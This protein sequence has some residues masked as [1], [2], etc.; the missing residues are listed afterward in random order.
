MLPQPGEDLGREHFD[1]TTKCC[2]YVP[3]L[4]NYL[5][6]RILADRDP[7]MA[8]GRTRVEARVDERIAVSPLGVMAPS[9]YFALHKPE[10]FGKSKALRCPYYLS[11]TG[12]CGVWRH[13]NAVCSTWFCKHERGAASRSFWKALEMALSEAERAIARHAVLELD[14]GAAVLAKLFPHSEDIESDPAPGDLDKHVDPQRYAT[15]WG[16]W[17][18]REREFF[19]RSATIAAKLTWE[20]VERIGGSELSARARV[21]R[22]ALAFL[23]AVALPKRVRVGA[24]EITTMSQATTSLTTYTPYD[25]ITVPNELLAVLP[26][27]DGVTTAQALATIRSEDG[28]ELD[29][30][31]VRRLIDFRVL[32]D[33]PSAVVRRKSTD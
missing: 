22:D 11:E 19:A 12:Q 31:L 18:G 32:L 28:I 4:H 27:F 16:R 2:T 7:A 5:I 26:R 1:P 30:G 13:R 29:E 8:A 9:H 17:L 33:E 14:V 15:L 10:R 6:G 21:T 25:P 24:F 23:N 20:D 3:R